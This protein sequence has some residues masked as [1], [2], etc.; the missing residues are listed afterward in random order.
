MPLVIL[1][2]VHIQV[3]LVPLVGLEHQREVLVEPVEPPRLVALVGAA[4]VMVQILAAVV[5]VARAEGRG[6]TI[7]VVRVAKVVP[8][9]S[10]VLMPLLP[11]VRPVGKV[12]LEP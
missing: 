2:L 11:P 6:T 5:A 7:Y 10:Q 9:A 1:G 8:M 4:E 12:G 3:G